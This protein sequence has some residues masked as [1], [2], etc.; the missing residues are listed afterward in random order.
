MDAPI[1]VHKVKK[2]KKVKKIKK[3]GRKHN[4]NGF[5]ITFSFSDFITDSDFSWDS[6]GGRHYGAH[7]AGVVVHNE[8]NVQVINNT[9]IIN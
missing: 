5:S 2:D 6:D 8:T 7:H 9:T 3:R 4:S 1:K